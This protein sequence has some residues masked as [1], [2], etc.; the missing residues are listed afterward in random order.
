MLTNHSYGAS[1]IRLLKRVRRGDRH[2][3]RDVVV[4]VRLEGALEEAFTRGDNELLL[5]ADSLKNTV[6]AVARETSFRE[7]EELALTLAEH[8]M[9]HQ[10]QLGLVRVDVSEVPW[11]RVAVGGRAQGQ[12]FTGGDGHRRTV[13]VTSNGQQVSVVAG[14]ERL[15]VMKTGGAAFEG[16]LRDQHTTLEESDDRILAAY[17]DAH[18]SYSSADVAFGPSWQGVR[19]LLLEAFVGEPS[20]SAEHTAHAMAELVLSSYVDIADVTVKLRQRML[21]LIELS[22]FGLDNPH[23]VFQPQEAP[24]EVAEATVARSR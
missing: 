18:W 4:A 2:D 8:V 15:L 17:L 11:Q 10:P 12:A 14:L 22:P 9:S 16:F 20:R 24:E 5:P 1:R 3:L 23:L 21:P 19:Q 7:I 13:T 6:H